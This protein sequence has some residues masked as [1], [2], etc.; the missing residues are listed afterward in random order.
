M[1]FNLSSLTGMVSTLAK[2]GLSPSQAFSAAKSLLTGTG[3]LKTTLLA[4]A[5]QMV[6]NEGDPANLKLIAANIATTVGA[7]PAIAA[8]AGAVASAATPVD[9]MSALTSLE[10]QINAL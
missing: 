6:V 4:Q 9:F 8:G 10:A 2:S 7:T 1:S 3:A 5:N